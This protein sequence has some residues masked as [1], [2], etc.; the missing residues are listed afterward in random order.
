M[1]EPMYQQIA[2]KIRAQIEQ[3]EIAPGD[4]LPTELE[5]RE[6]YSAS[7]NTIRDAIK[8]L[9]REGLVVTQAGR[10][11]FVP[12]PIDPF[13]TLLTTNPEV[14]GD[15]GV[16]Y[17]S[18]VRKRRREPHVSDPQVEVQ[19][20][21]GVITKRLVV[22]VGEKIVCRRQRRFID[23][24]PYSL[25][26]TWYPYRFV[27]EG[28]SELL[29][30]ID[31]EQGIVALLRKKLGLEQKGYTDII[32]VRQPHD[33]EV[34]FFELARGSGVSICEIARI[35]YDAHQRPYRLTVTVYPSDRNVFQ[36]NVGQVPLPGDAA[37]GLEGRAA[38]QE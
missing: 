21:K 34:A 38:P 7:R 26:T 16:A 3:G 13:V 29:E 10:G 35:G 31:F 37:G 8:V 5:L 36:V 27:E 20:A 28:V 32:E 15:D 12:D 30:A 14:V 33:P 22:E 23:D 1:V 25:Q 6:E 24:K 2:Q 18:E 17:K 4:R 11:T 19:R 9:T